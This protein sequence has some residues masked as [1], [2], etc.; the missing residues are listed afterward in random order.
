MKNIY[1][2][3]INFKNKYSGTIAFRLDKHAKVL[4]NYI[5]DDE[6]VLYAFCAQLNSEWYDI[7]SSCAIVLTNQRILVGKK[8]LLWGSS[9][10]QVTPELYND[11][12]IYE[13]LFFGNIIIDTVKE[14][15]YLSKISKKALDEIET[16]ISKFMMQAKNEIKE[17][18][19]EA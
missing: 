18:E 14:K 16:N 12:E 15:I 3:I 5:N 4:E 2:K 13:G 19:N 6:E 7:C 9:Y 8:R 17:D 10:M 1:E 11:M